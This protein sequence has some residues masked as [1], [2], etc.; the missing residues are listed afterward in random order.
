[1]LIKNA[2]LVDETGV[3]MGDICME[4]GKITAIGRELFGEGP[5][6]DAKGRAV[7]PAFIDLHCHFRTPGFTHKEDLL[8]GS[9][10]AARG[11]YSFVNCMANTMP[12]CSTRDIADSVMQKAREINLCG[13]NQCISITK[14]FDG[15]TL[16]HLHDLPDYLRCISDDGNGV[17]S[18]AVMEQAMRIAKEKGLTIFSH[19]ED[20]TLSSTD[21]RLAEDLETIRNLYLAAYTGAKLHLCHV[22][23]YGALNAIRAARHEG[24]AVTFE[25][26]PHHIWFTSGDYRVNPPI[27]T[28][29]DTAA[30]IAAMKNGEVNAIA[31]DHAPHTDADKAN[32]APGMVGLETA[33]GVCYTKLCLENALPLTALSRMMSAEPARILNLPKGLLRPGYD[34]DVVVVD[35]EL[36][37]TVRKADFYSKSRNTPFDGVR[38]T[39]KVEMTVKAGEITFVSER[40]IE[41]MHG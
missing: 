1:M 11:G 34:A 26:T 22:S 3:V 14:D 35:T 36:P 29:K 23:T 20:K 21:Y 39:G 17:Q 2:R 9:R 30:L 10:A 18:G 19:A 31:T 16:T 24:L 38:L 37:Y 27:R 12:I 28:A 6:I 8:S 25:V 32:G 41:K 15:E 7:L 40:P 13:V 5:I 4:N 33:F